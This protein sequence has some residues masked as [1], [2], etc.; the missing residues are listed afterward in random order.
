MK[1]KEKNFQE[2]EAAVLQVTYAHIGEGR[3]KGP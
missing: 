3:V 2:A 1:G